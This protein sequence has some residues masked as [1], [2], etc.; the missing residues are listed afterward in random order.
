MFKALL[1][2]FFISKMLY[3][4]EIVNFLPQFQRFFTKNLQNCVLKF[5]K[6]LHEVIP[7]YSKPS[8]TGVM[9]RFFCLEINS[10]FSNPILMFFDKSYPKSLCC[11]YCIS[12]PSGSTVNIGTLR[13]EFL[14]LSCYIP[15]LYK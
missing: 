7:S 2:M 9:S 15:Q 1:Y 6:S 8:C 5:P 12:P 3:R 14:D 4:C 13:K 10:Q 11:S